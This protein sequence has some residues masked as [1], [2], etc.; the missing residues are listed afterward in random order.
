MP[1][2]APCGHCPMNNRQTT[3]RTIGDGDRTD[4]IARHIP[5]GC[6]TTSPSIAAYRELQQTGPFK[7]RLPFGEPI[8]IATRYEDVKHG[9]WRSTDGQGGGVSAATRRACTKWSTDQTQ[10]TRQHGS[11]RTTPG[12]AAWLRR[13]SRR[14]DQGHDRVDR[15]HGR[16]RSSTTSVAGQRRRFHGALFAWKLPLQVITAIIGAPVEDDPLA[17]RRG[18]TTSPGPDIIPRAAIRGV[19]EHSGLRPGTHRR[20]AR[21]G[22]R[23]PSLSAG[24]GA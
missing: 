9:L 15:G 13:P 19:R 1:C 24:T 7:A 10:P 6:T 20:T 12:S 23:R 17:A 21:A 11:A 4:G 18:S 2:P 5:S 3:R 8:W 16:P 14:P 22:D